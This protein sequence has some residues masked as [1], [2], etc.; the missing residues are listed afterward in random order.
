MVMEAGTVMSLMM[1][2]VG[3][4]FE[5]KGDLKRGGTINRL[6]GPP[7]VVVFISVAESGPIINV[8]ARADCIDDR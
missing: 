2:N 7:L 3:T 6:P 8:P 1:L 5:R 4:R